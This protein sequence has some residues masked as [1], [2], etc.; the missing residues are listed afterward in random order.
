MPSQ[1]DIIEERVIAAIRKRREHGLNKY[2]VGVER[3]DLSI[4]QWI[5][6]AKEEAMD[7][8]VY[9]E[10]IQAMNKPRWIFDLA[11][12]SKQMWLQPRTVCECSVGPADIS[13]VRGFKPG[14]CER[15]LL[16]EPLPSLAL[17]AEQE[18]GFSIHKVAIG[19]QQG[20]A[21]LIDNGGSSYLSG[22]WSPTP[23]NDNPRVEVDVVTFDTLDDGEID[24]LNLDCEGHEWAVLCN[25]RSR[26]LL[27]AIE[28]WEGNPYTTEITDWLQAN[29]YT[30]RFSTGP[31]SETI[32]YSRT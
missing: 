17:A 7:L 1:P 4:Q 25:M 23:V 29:N 8:S 15:F 31:T 14:D 5:Q 11:W 28:V 24:I 13:I 9:L 27:L 30:P 16:T 20:R 2:K 32:I 10:R 26:P 22:T 3:T 18:F 21:S 6:H 12:L 19:F